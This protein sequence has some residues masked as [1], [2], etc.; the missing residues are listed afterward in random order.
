MFI[1]CIVVVQFVVG[2]CG[3]FGESV[4]GSAAVNGRFRSFL[5]VLMVFAFLG[6]N[7]RLIRVK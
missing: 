1:P 3:V 6:F 5:M 4:P 7:Y 2:Q